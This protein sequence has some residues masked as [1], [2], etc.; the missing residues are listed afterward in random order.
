MEWHPSTPENE[1]VQKYFIDVYEMIDDIDEIDKRNYCKY[2]KEV[3]NEKDIVKTVICC[4]DQRAY[5]EFFQR[6]GNKTC[7]ENDLNCELTYEYVLFH[8]HVLHTLMMAD[9]DKDPSQRYKWKQESYESPKHHKGTM[10]PIKRKPDHSKYYLHSHIIDDERTDSIVVPNLKPFHLYAFYVYACNSVSNC[11]DYYFHSDRTY[12]YPDADNIGINAKTLEGRSDFIT[13]TIKPPAEPNGVTVAFEIK[14]YDW[15]RD[16]IDTKC[17]TRK[18][19]VNMN[20][21]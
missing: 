8:H 12:P 18:E 3:K 2:P 19:M 10:D 20:Y 5:L 4:R 14:I 11:S 1:L 9:L 16:I 6:D 15:N 7:G 21:T 17:L 13:L